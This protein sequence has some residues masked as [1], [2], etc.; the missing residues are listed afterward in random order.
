MTFEGFRPELISFFRELAPNNT[1]EWFEAHRADYEQLWLEPAQAAVIA[2]G[3]QLRAIAPAVHAEP[4]IRGSIFAINRDTRFSKDKS[5][6]KTYLDLWFWQGSGP[7]RECPG[8]FLRLQAE[9]LTLGAG[10]HAFSGARLERY[11][12]AVSDTETAASLQRV[13]DKVQAH[14]GQAVGGQTLKRV[15]SGYEAKSEDQAQLLRHTGLYA[16]VQFEP[17]PA[18]VFS[19]QLPAFCL[20]HFQRVAPLQQWLVQHLI[21]INA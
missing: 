13:I 15:P 6:Y 17:L 21:K 11:R 7:S 12:T 8:Y 18:E 9:Q 5:P 19:A 4:R 10:M 1:R 20:E 14:E 16:H 3:D 2:I